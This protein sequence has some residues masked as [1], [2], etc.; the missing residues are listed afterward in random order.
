MALYVGFNVYLLKCF[1]KV[2]VTKS[3]RLQLFYLKTAI[4]II[5]R[6]LHVI[7]K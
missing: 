4:F 6:Q 7:L 3:I 1:W 5:T 2:K